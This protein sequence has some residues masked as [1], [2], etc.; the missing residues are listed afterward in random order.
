M[1]SG[2]L[3]TYLFLCIFLVACTSAPRPVKYGTDNCIRCRMT[4]VEQGF[5]A[6]IVTKK[7]KILTFDSIEC[8]LKYY[9]ANAGSKE[10]YAY[11]MVT[12]ATKPGLLIDA[13][14]A[15]YLKSEKLPS[16]MGENLSAYSNSELREKNYTEFSG[17]RLSWTELCNLFTR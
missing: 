2:K 3:A 6:E 10:T 1:N 7:G 17:Q 12:D 11:I 4:I 13:D 16:P 9:L 15:V 14:K 5:G 8:M